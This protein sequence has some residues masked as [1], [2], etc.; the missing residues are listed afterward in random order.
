MIIDELI[1]RRYFQPE[2]SIIFI[3]NAESSRCDPRALMYATTKA[4][5]E[6][7]AG[8]LCSRVGLR[9]VKLVLV[10]GLL[11]FFDS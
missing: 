2:S 11:P 7:M 10:V 9:G 8:L 3:S 1:K 4:A 5:S 6:A